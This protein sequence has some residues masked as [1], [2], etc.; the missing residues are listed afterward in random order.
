MIILF[1]IPYSVFAKSSFV[2]WNSRVKIADENLDIKGSSKN[3]DAYV[4]NGPQGCA[5]FLIRFFQIVI[6]PQDGPNCRFYPTCSSYGKVAVQ[7]YGAIIGA[8]LA[9]D[10]IIRCN[11]FSPPGEDLLPRSIFGK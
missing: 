9:G 3:K 2:P 5:Y 11:P 10:R 4:Y 8:M 7:T 1:C 6:S